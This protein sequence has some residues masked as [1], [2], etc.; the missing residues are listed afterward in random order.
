MNRDQPC[1]RG[2]WKVFAKDLAEK[3]KEDVHFVKS[4]ELQKGF[5]RPGKFES[6]GGDIFLFYRRQNV[7]YHTL[8]YA[9]LEKT[10][11]LAGGRNLYILK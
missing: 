4:S 9:G 1:P 11:S 2:S 5:A 10:S 3:V 6:G 8:S 7:F